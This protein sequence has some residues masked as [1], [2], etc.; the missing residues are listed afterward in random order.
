M[1]TVTL[2]FV[3]VNKATSSELS[4]ISLNTGVILYRCLLKIEVCKNCSMFVNDLHSRAALYC[5]KVPCC[6]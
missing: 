1:K 3:T 2:G 6:Y 5:D 4:W